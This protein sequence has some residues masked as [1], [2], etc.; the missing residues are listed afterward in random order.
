MAE[1]VASRRSVGSWKPDSSC[2]QCEECN[3]PFTLF[4]RRHHCRRCGGIFCAKCSAGRVALPDRGYAT[5]VRVC[6]SCTISALSASA[7]K[8]F[9][10]HSQGSLPSFVTDECERTPGPSTGSS[11]SPPS[12]SRMSPPRGSPAIEVPGSSAFKTVPIRGARESDLCRSLERLRTCSED[13]SSLGGRLSASPPLEFFSRPRSVV[14]GPVHMT[15]QLST[16]GL[17][18][19]LNNTSL[20]SQ[21][22]LVRRESNKSPLGLSV[23]NGSVSSVAPRSAAA[24]AGIE[25]GMQIVSIDE[26]PVRSDTDAVEALRRC[27]SN[28]VQIVIKSKQRGDDAVQNPAP[29]RA[30]SMDEKMW[31]GRVDATDSPEH[32]L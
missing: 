3:L 20:G 1:S 7:L 16:H 22:L 9:Y 25:V 6:G 28:D 27:A 17:S 10:R 29:R 5:P 2:T 12:Q 30:A 21:K 4:R 11:T 23:R 26:R 14:R 32:Y 24:A 13:G 15:R 18:T 19:S 31:N 8:G